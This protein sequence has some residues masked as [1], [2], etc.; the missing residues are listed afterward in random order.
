[1]GQRRLAE[2]QQVQLHAG[3]E[4]IRALRE[5]RPGEGERGPDRGHH[6]ADQGQVQHFLDGDPAQDLVPARDSSRLPLREA[7]VGVA[8]QAEV[9]VQ[10]LAH[11]HV[12]ELRRLG[13]QVPQ[14]LP[15]LDDDPGLCHGCAPEGQ[16]DRSV[17]LT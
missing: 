16:F 5:V 13:Q 10:V 14:V 3:R 6:V 15:M 4:V 1:M 7:L 17:I 12:L 8:L 11:D 9:G 2:R